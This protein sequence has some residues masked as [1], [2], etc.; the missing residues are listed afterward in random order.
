MHRKRELDPVA[1]AYICAKERFVAENATPGQLSL[2]E[3]LSVGQGPL[4]IDKR[5]YQIERKTHL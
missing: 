1:Q 2:F 4:K 5:D 3:D